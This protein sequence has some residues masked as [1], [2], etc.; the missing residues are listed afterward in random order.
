M[1]EVRLESAG[2]AKAEGE[3]RV[4]A[5]ADAQALEAVVRGRVPGAAASVV[6]GRA[7][8][9][10]PLVAL[11]P[12]EVI[13]LGLISNRGMVLVAAALG[14]IWQSLP[15]DWM[16]DG[17]ENMA[18]RLP[19]SEAFSAVAAGP[20]TLVGLALAL[21]L[22][23]LVVVRLLSVTLA[24][25]QFYDFRLTDLGGRLR[26][27]RG[28]LTRL[29]SH[30]PTRRIQAWHIEETLLHRWF[31][32]QSVR[33]DSAASPAGGDRGGTRDLVPLATPARVSA[34]LPTFLPHLAWPPVAWRPLHPLAWRRLVVVPTLVVLATTT[35]LVWRVGPLGSL[36][37]LLVAPVFY[38]AKRWAGSAGYAELHGGLITMRE[39]WLTRTWRLAEVRKLQTLRISQSPFDRRHRMA[40]LW[41][42][43]AGARSRDAAFRIPFLP[44]DEA[45]A[46]YARLTAGLDGD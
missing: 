18:L 11:P 34:L 41:I 9:E 7:A 39:G 24:F 36:A 12:G 19:A 22:A 20:I 37:A 45:Y 17:F 5:L 33:I 30:V 32:R 44:V 8:R 46:V 25:L 27:E 23:A 38:R 28:L 4:L 13:R 21:I 16:R 3:M 42:D 15:D 35:V 29:R 31:G 14:A 10:V 43:T 1:A 26:I 2:G 6:D 40:T